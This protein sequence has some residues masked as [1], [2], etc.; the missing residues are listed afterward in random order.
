MED[1]VVLRH[2]SALFFDHQEINILKCSTKLMG[3][4]RQLKN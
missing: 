4:M 3:L 1:Y 2:Y